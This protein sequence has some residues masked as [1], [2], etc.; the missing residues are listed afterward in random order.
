MGGL[1]V[2]VYLLNFTVGVLDSKKFGNFK[3]VVV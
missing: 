3:K 1:P 2:G